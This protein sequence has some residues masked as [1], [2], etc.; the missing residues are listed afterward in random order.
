MANKKEVEIRIV[1]NGY[2]DNTIIYVDGEE[3]TVQ[4]FNY[5][6]SVP[7]RVRGNLRG[8]KCS[9]QVQREIGGKIY[10]MKFYAGDFE[11]LAEAREL[12]DEKEDEEQGRTNR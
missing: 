3:W 2:F 8:G 4:E 9:F 5:S 11:K 1:T 6:A 7:H 12:Q 10:P